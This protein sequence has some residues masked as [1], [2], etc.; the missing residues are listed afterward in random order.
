MVFD[1]SDSVGTGAG[2]IGA[3]TGAVATG[4]GMFDMPVGRFRRGGRAGMSYVS[5][6]GAGAG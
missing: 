3:G 5:D 2:D 1:A 6:V 4:A